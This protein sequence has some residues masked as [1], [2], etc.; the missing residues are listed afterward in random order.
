MILCLLVNV[1][2]WLVLSKSS[3]FPKDRYLAFITDI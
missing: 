2:E 1:K 3:D